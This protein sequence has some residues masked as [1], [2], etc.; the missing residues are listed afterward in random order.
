MVSFEAPSGNLRTLVIAIPFKEFSIFISSFN[1]Q[2]ES[3]NL[4]F[5]TMKQKLRMTSAPTV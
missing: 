3:A 1:F 4:F 2:E 5:Q